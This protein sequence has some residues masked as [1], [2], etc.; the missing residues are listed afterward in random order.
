M[1]NIYKLPSGCVEATAAVV[2]VVIVV[3]V[4]IIHRVQ[5]DDDEAMHVLR[6]S[7]NRLV[8]G[9]THQGVCFTYYC[10]T[11]IFIVS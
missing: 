7:V 9:P 1:M 4:N 10:K 2:V 11:T 6:G 8:C 5:A 3:V